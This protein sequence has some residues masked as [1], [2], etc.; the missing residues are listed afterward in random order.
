MVQAPE[1]SEATS[2]LFDL[3]DAPEAFVKQRQA[4]LKRKRFVP[5][6][7]QLP[8][9]VLPE[10]GLISIIDQGPEGLSVGVALAALLNYLRALTGNRKPVSS[11]MLYTFAQRYDEWDGHNYDGSSL[12]GAILG[13]SEK[14]VCLEE[15]W[16]LPRTGPL[17]DPAVMRA[18]LLNRPAEMLS[19]ELRKD[20][21]RA[22]IFEHK[23]IV[24][25]LT[26][27]K[28]WDHVQRGLIPF[29][30]QQAKTSDYV[31][32]GHAIAILGYTP[33]GFLI[34]NSWGSKWTTAV[35]GKRR[36]PGMAILSYE[37]A[38]KNL[39]DAWAL[40][41]TQ[42]PFNPP[43]VGYD[44][45]SLS[46]PDMLEIRAEVDA[47]SYVLASSTIRPP[48]ALGLFGDWGS[49]KSFFMQAMQRKIEALSKLDMAGPERFC[50]RIV[51]IRFNAWHYLDADLWASLVTEIFDRLFEAVS[52]KTNTPEAKLASLTEELKKANGMYQQ[53]QNQ[54]DDATRAKTAAEEA[55]KSAVKERELQENKLATQLDDFSQL[56]SDDPEVKAAVDELSTALGIPEMAKSFQAF[57]NQAGKLDSV[58]N[59]LSTLLQAMFATPQGYWRLGTLVAALLAPVGIVAALE[60][61]QRSDVLANPIQTFHSFA[62]QLSG[63]VA[64]LTAWLG[65]QVR[66]GST[67]VSQLEDTQR[68]LEAIRAKRR[69]R[70]VANESETLKTLNAREELARRKLLEAEQRVD[71]LEQE[72]KDQQIGRLITRFIEE[73]SRATEYRSRLGIVSLIRQDLQ[74]LSELADPS[75]PPEK[76]GLMPV[77]RIILYIDDLDRCKPDRVIEVLE[78]VHLLLAFPLFMVVV[79]VDPRW[80]RHCL[81]KHYPDLL[82]SNIVQAA[83]LGHAL[84]SRPATAQDYLEKIFQIPFLLQ[85]L[86]DEGYRRMISGLTA[87]S[88]MQEIAPAAPIGGTTPTEQPTSSH[89]GNAAAALPGTETPA[90]RSDDQRDADAQAANLVTPAQAA[91]FAIQ[92]LEFRAWEVEDM[93]RLA[94][95]FL[96]PRAVKR[97][98]NTYRF[99]RAGIRVVEMPSFE[100][101][102][103][104]PGTCRAAM[105]LLA[106][107]VNHAL[108]AARFMSRIREQ[109]HEHNVRWLT[110]LKRLQE[111]QT[112]NH[113]AHAPGPRSPS[114]KANVTPVAVLVPASP[115]WDQVEWRQLCDILLSLS[116]AS[117][118]VRDVVELEPWIH[119]VSR[120]SF[121]LSA[122]TSLRSE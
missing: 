113:A 12:A 91:A 50:Q 94:P 23:A 2:D 72:V 39:T 56:L 119:T 24:V 69:E 66:R 27:H 13:L 34:Q 52:G 40:M 118:P 85:P 31:T 54:L 112:A 20:A 89:G 81:E 5:K 7:V 121:S 120:Y 105:L 115:T 84:P 43:Q 32:G 87:G 59:R 48:L 3:P 46:G 15:E 93:Q 62:L 33:Q 19:V 117:F 22:A 102:R 104:S 16:P 77:E 107:T 6:T 9:E 92:Q 38:Q 109:K 68:K 75:A 100:G 30:P 14:G 78:A 86:K 35:V 99:L 45:D 103:A 64:A 65:T 60:F 97:F 21:L 26:V 51:P 80:L 74:R 79:A 53:A 8:D 76:K 28:D 10:P 47:F 42:A 110:F 71:A 18:A 57:E 114:G 17:P 37:D 108:V 41:L 122:T 29:D 25:S 36:Y 55:L 106:I 4:A 1:T 95:L 88:V 101:T 73:R 44:A 116:D 111:E 67:L 61:L 49:G 58:S 90:D 63:T 98:V 70:A 11:R 96:T 83:P 82:S